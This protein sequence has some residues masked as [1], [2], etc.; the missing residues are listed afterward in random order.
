MIHVYVG[1]TLP[2]STSQLSAPGVQVHPPA[3]H[4]DLFDDA[5]QDGDTVVL[6]D[7]VFHQ[8]PALR[9][10]EILAAMGRGV[11][12]IGAASIG[13][14]RA[15]ELDAFGMVG[16][17]SVYAAYVRGQFSGDD[18]VAVGQAP[19]R[20]WAALTWPVVSLS[21]VLHLAVQANVL[22]AAHADRLLCALRAVYYP[23]RTLA[24]VRAVCARENAGDVARWLDQQRAE[25]P[26][27]GDIKR[28][29][30][31]LALQVAHDPRPPLPTRFQCP[32]G[33]WETAYYRRWANSFA[34]ER[35]DGTTLFTE[36]RVLYQQVFD[37]RFATTWTAYLEHCSRHPA[38]GPGRPLSEQLARAGGDLRADQI[39]RPVVD[40]RDATTVTLLLAGET[41]EDRQSVAD[42]RSVLD[43]RRQQSGVT[44]EAVSE[45]LTRR[46]LLQIWQCPDERLDTEASSRGL[47]CAAAAVAAARRFVPGGLQETAAAAAPTRTTNQEAAHVRD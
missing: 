36:D 19:D 21:H 17:G 41:A 6:L 31:L 15:C 4:G 5:V 45:D 43:A 42:Y 11:R 2:R 18:E 20:D 8:A 32:P 44:A 38:A 12:V 1:P 16:V 46:L 34:T 7:G 47:V 22:E 39:F 40:L 37:Q 3:R 30:A 35:V 9:H 26:H 13:A 25:E 33:V 23:Q 10:K 24:A 28:A 27:F 29:D 14:L